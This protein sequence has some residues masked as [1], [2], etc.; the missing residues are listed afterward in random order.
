MYDKMSKLLAISSFS[1]FVIAG[2]M[3]FFDY[4]PS[5]FAKGIVGFLSVVFVCYF[6][7]CSIKTWFWAFVA[8]MPISWV[9]LFREIAE[10]N[11]I[12]IYAESPVMLSFFVALSGL[13][14][15]A[16]YKFVFETKK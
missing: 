4:E 15:F 14:V 12:S 9:F 11:A 10:Q 16:G 7:E 3:I 2:L 13:I 8:L 6:Y 5:G 1:L